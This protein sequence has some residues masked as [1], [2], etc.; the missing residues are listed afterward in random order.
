MSCLV[1]SRGDCGF[2]GVTIPY[3]YNAIGREG[4]GALH[5]ERL[6]HGMEWLDGPTEK[7]A[8]LPA[9]PK[10]GRKRSEKHLSCFHFHIFLS[11][12]NGNRNIGNRN[13]RTYSVNQKRTKPI[14]IIPE[15]IGNR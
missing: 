12:G 9:K 13:E 5:S 7:W 10:N 3:P 2:P 4:P 6:G 8:Q 15:T 1:A 14:R 11:D